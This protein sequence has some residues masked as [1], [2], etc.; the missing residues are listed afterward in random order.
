ERPRPQLDLVLGHGC[1]ERAELVDA[2][3]LGVVSVGRLHQGER[4]AHF[5]GLTARGPCAYRTCPVPR[6]RGSREDNRAVLRP[7]TLVPPPLPKRPRDEH[8]LLEDGAIVDGF[9]E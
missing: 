3:V 1:E 7:A 9:F 5:R 6:G 2:V 8:V 4:V